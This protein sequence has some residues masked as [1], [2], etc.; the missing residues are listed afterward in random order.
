MP[1][2]AVAGKGKD[3]TAVAVGRSVLRVRE[4]G[5][6]PD[7]WQLGSIKGVHFPLRC[8]TNNVGRRSEDAFVQ[9][10]QKQNARA[11]QA[12]GQEKGRGKEKDKG[13]NGK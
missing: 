8:F 3:P 1:L 11:A 12:R 10:R 2:P 9:R 7:V 4:K 5:L 13:G 6:D